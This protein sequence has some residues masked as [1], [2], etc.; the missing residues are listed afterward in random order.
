MITNLFRKFTNLWLPDRALQCFLLLLLVQDEQLQNTHLQQP[1]M[2]IFIFF[3]H[4]KPDKKNQ[5]KNG[6]STNVPC[7]FTFIFCINIV[8]SHVM[9]TPFTS[10][11]VLGTLSQFGGAFIPCH[12]CIIKRHLALEGRR[13][14]FVHNNILYALCELNWF[15]CF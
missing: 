2:L 11:A 13:L 8:N 6:S 12:N 14:V 3:Y 1:R 15:R 10:E 7:I 4:L 9:T 5:I